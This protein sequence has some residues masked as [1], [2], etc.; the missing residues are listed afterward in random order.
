MEGAELLRATM[1]QV[2]LRLDIVL[3][4]Q[5]LRN[6]LFV[7]TEVTAHNRQPT[8]YNKTS[9]PPRS[10]A[11]PI[12]YYSKVGGKNESISVCPERVTRVARIPIIFWRDGVIGA[13]AHP[14]ALK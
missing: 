4:S 13:V 8:Y 2:G 1:E 5:G 6:L 10:F 7:S 9:N 11:L 12:N 14:H 3:L